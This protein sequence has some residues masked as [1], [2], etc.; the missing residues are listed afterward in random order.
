MI[1]PLDSVDCAGADG[2]TAG[3]VSTSIASDF[4]LFASTNSGDSPSD[5]AKSRSSSNSSALPVMVG[6]SVLVISWST[7][8]SLFPIRFSYPMYIGVPSHFFVP[9]LVALI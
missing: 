4:F 3:S 5:A 6:I 1:A 7:S 2:D 9:T 8:K